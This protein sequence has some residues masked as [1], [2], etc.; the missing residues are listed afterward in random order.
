MSA[1]EIQFHAIPGFEN[2]KISRDGVVID[3]NNQAVKIYNP[4]NTSHAHIIMKKDGH[5]YVRRIHVILHKLF[6][7]YVEND[8]YKHIPGY[9]DYVISYYGDVIDTT[10][11]THLV[12]SKG[13]EP[14][15]SLRCDDG[16]HR[17]KTIRTLLD[18]TYTEQDGEFRVIPGFENYKISRE[19]VIINTRNNRTLKYLSRKNYAILSKNSVT[20]GF[21]IH[22]LLEL[23]WKS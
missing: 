18:L 4:T 20:Q 23:T 11:N 14:S 17:M 5:E 15:V 22:T 7:Q 10:T 21:P 9:E 6:N 19:G 1:V 3:E 16:K 8:D 13:K 12:I 2:Y